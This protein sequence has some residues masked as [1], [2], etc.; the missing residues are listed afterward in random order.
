MEIY[1]RVDGDR[2]A[3]ATFITDGCGSSMVC[4]S[5]AAELS[6]GRTLTE[7]LDIDEN[8]IKKRVGGLPKEDEHCAFLAASTLHEAVNNY[9]KK[10]TQKGQ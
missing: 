8:M 6:Q 7:A 10:I 4:G 1:I 3:D 2:I 9:M 5:F